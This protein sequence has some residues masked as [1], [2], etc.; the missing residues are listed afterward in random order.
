MEEGPGL[1]AEMMR[2]GLRQ[3]KWETPFLK[4]ASY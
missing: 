4:G 2:P 3:R 1:M